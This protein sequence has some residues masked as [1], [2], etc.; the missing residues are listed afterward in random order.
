MLCWPRSRI[1]GTGQPKYLTEH[2]CDGIRPLCQQCSSYG[3]TCIFSETVDAHHTVLLKRRFSMLEERSDH[4]HQ[5]LEWLRSSHHADAVRLLRCL[6]AG[7]DAHSIVDFALD[8]RSAHVA[9]RVMPSDTLPADQSSVNG[10]TLPRPNG[11]L[12]IATREMVS[13]ESN[14][15]SLEGMHQQE[16]VPVVDARGISLPSFQ[17]LLYDTT[18]RTP[19]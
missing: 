8:L 2:Q 6:R 17:T 13:P 11:N 10:V 7:D 19:T 18:Q 5:V 12:L 4:E 15:E 14:L 3:S 16:Q 9:S 1:G